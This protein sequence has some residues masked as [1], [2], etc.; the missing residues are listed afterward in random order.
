MWLKGNDLLFF[1]ALF[2]VA[3]AAALIGAQGAIALWHNCQTV[4]DD[5]H[6]ERPAIIRSAAAAFS[7]K[8]NHE[9]IK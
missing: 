8:E 3:N 2:V 9:E 1:L 6:L 7:L 4:L 5:R